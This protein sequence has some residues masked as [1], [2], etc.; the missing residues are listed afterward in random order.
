MVS[1]R[2]F[3][4]FVPEDIRIP[5]SSF[6]ISY[7]KKDISK[8]SK[9]RI[10]KLVKKGDVVYDTKKGEFYL[11]LK[12]K[13][14]PIKLKSEDKI[15]S[16]MLNRIKIN[17]PQNF[18]PVNSD[19]YKAEFCYFDPFSK[20]W[21]Q[22]DRRQVPTMYEGR[23]YNYLSTMLNKEIHDYNASHGRTLK[24]SNLE[25]ITRFLINRMVN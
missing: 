3:K 8:E 5:N 1:H 17:L 18:F 11:K 16:Y 14:H 25:S 10:E 20:S 7:T 13:K 22:P 24:Q 2:A 12:G 19:L 9:E 4:K 23:L 15:P 6:E 21:I